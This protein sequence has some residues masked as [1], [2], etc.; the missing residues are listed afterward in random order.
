MVEEKPIEELTFREAMAELDRIV[1]VLESNS[2]ELEQ[3]VTSY[4]RGVKLI[5]SLKKRIDGAQ[6]RIDALM[7]ELEKPADDEVRDTD[8]VLGA[9]DGSLPIN[10]GLTTVHQRLCGNAGFL[11]RAKGSLRVRFSSRMNSGT[12]C[13][14]RTARTSAVCGACLQFIKT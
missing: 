4:E 11:P 10:L 7:G 3:S 13:R 2:L 9:S 12:A 1:G 14:I 8:A 5:A 6:Q